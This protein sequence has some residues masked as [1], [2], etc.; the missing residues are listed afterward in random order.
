MGFYL[1][2]GPPQEY[3][4]RTLA[5]IN[6]TFLCAR[7]YSTAFY[8]VWIRSEG[9]VFH[10]RKRI[11]TADTD[12]TYVKRQMISVLDPSEFSSAD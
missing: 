5:Y 6:D 12:D 9:A 11:V 8:G 4:A 2:I 3:F 1:A 7:R 10:Q